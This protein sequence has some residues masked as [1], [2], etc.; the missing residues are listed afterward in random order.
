LAIL[1]VL[2]NW[3]THSKTK[4]DGFCSI[5]NCYDRTIKGERRTTNNAEGFHNA[6]RS[7]VGADHPTIWRF[8]ES[9]RKT[10]RKNEMAILQ[11]GAGHNP[12]QR[13]KAYRD[14]DSRLKKVVQSYGTMGTLEYL[15]SVASIIEYVV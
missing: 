6:F 10:Q 12:P 7:L 9:L 13:K 4:T 14:K 11:Y 1:I 2:Y 3:F 5:W 8:I 15:N